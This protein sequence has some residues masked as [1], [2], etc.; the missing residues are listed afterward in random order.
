MNDMFTDDGD[1]KYVEDEE[2][3]LEYYRKRKMHIVGLAADQE[4]VEEILQKMA[5]DI[6]ARYGT[7]NAACVKDF[8]N[9]GNIES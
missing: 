1:F 6:I 5:V 9:L 7:F 4:G 3:F 8:F 2:E